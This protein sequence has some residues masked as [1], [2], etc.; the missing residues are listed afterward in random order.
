MH[1]SCNAKSRIPRWE[2]RDRIRIPGG[3]PGHALRYARK[4]EMPPRTIAV[5][6]VSGNLV[7]F[8]RE[9][10]S[11]LLRERIARGEAHGALNMGVGSR[12]LA[13][14][15][16]RPPAFRQCPRHTRRREL[17]AGT[18]RRAR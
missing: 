5:L 2:N 14:P 1:S 3:R 13:A 9:D 15:R 16:E 11:S 17:G 10:R 18:G 4:Q 7:P 8:V 12:A 6:D